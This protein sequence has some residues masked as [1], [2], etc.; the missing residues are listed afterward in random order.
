[1]MNFDVSKQI[2][3]VGLERTGLSSY[4]CRYPVLLA[5]WLKQR[6]YRE[7]PS[8][9]GEIARLASPQAEVR[10]RETGSVRVLGKGA[11]EVHDVLQTLIKA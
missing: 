1:M 11:T 9:R 8:R 7:R 2:S 3:F 5:A 10:V 6:G 4:R